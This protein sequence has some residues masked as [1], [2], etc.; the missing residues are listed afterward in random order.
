MGDK[1]NDNNKPYIDWGSIIKFMILFVFL[2]GL[3][4]VFFFI[5]K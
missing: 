1:V 5:T 3:N 4:L 2:F